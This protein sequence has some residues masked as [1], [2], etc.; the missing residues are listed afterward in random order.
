MI[1]HIAERAQWTEARRTDRY[2]WST[3]GLGVE[4][5]GYAH[6]SFESQWLAVRQRF[7]GDLEDRDLV[8]LVIDES[9]LSSPVVVECIDGAPEEFPHVYGEIDIE[10]VVEE[11]AIG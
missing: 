2:R 8:L 11:R 7:Y 10:A 4:E 6:C 9:K 1:Y 3:R 5:V